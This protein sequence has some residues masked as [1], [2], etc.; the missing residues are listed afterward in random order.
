MKQAITVDEYDAGGDCHRTP[1]STEAQN[2][3][4]PARVSPKVLPH[5]IPELQTPI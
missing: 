3:I 2:Q 5:I 1:G 4:I